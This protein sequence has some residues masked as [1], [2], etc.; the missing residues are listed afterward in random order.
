MLLGPCLAAMTA[1]AAAPDM[2]EFQ[3]SCGIWSSLFPSQSYVLYLFAPDMSKC[4]VERGE[5]DTPGSKLSS[6]DRC[7]L[8]HSDNPSHQPPTHACGGISDSTDGIEDSASYETHAES[9][10]TVVND[11]PGAGFSVIFFHNSV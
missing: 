8:L 9:S 10:T 3:G 2:M 11:P 1:P 6:Q 4:A 7:S 5:A